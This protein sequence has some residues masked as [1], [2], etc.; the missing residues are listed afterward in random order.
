V[1][2]AIL[3]LVLVC[4]KHCLL[5]HSF[6]SYCATCSEW[7]RGQVYPPTAAKNQTLIFLHMEDSGWNERKP[8]EM[9]TQFSLSISLSI[10]EL[11]N[12]VLP[13]PACQKAEDFY[14]GILHAV[15]TSLFLVLPVWNRNVKQ[16]PRI[17]F[18]AVHSYW[19]LQARTGAG[20]AG[21]DCKKLP[22]FGELPEQ[23]LNVGAVASCCHQLWCSVASGPGWVVFVFWYIF[24]LI[25]STTRRMNLFAIRL[26]CS[27]NLWQLW[28]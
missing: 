2:F 26:H 14:R 4:Y 8:S 17:F 24:F 21:S 25:F 5:T 28:T 6:T 12:Q 18:C 16:S 22:L 27:C 15:L 3:V 13:L 10:L 1:G 19:F 20:K 9:L 23:L 7:G 11:M